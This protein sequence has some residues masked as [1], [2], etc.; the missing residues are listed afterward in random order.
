LESFE[1]Y[2]AKNPIQKGQGD[3]NVTPPPPVPKRVNSF[4][5]LLVSPHE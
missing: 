4:A 2:A 1:K 5:D 3:K